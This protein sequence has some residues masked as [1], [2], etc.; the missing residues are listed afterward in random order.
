[1]IE[2]EID[3]KS[4]QVE[5][6]KMIIEVADEVG[7]NIPRF[8]YHKKLSVAAN[9]RMCLV[10]VEK[11][12]KPLPACATPVTPGMK[13][14]TQSPKAIDS[15]RGVMEFLLINHPLDCP[16]C[17]QGGE[18]ELQDLSMGYGNDS[19]RFD[20]GKRSVY[21]ENLGP[22]IA[23]YMT[24]CIQCTR[25]VR[26]GTEIAGIRE[27]GAT[28]RGENMEIETYVQ[29]AMSSELSGNIIDLCPV[30]ALTSKP[31]RFQARPWE[32]EQTASVAPHDCVGSNIYIHT[33]RGELM[34]VVPRNQDEIN[35]CWLSDRDRFSYTAVHSSK[36][37][38]KPMIKRD[39]KWHE[40]DWAA[41][42]YYAVEGFQRTFAATSADQMGG[43]ISPSATLEEHFLFQKC[44]R[45]LGTSNIDH[46]VRAVDTADQDD[47]PLFPTL[48]IPIVELAN[49]ANVLLIGSHIQHEQPLLSHR[50]R[51][52]VLQGANVACINPVDYDFNFKVKQKWIVAPDQIVSNLAALIKAWLELSPQAV[53]PEVEKFIQSIEVTAAH[54]ETV[55]L[56]Q[57]QSL[58]ILLGAYVES[59]PQA[60]TLRWLAHQ[61]AK[62]TLANMGC[63]TTG[64]NAAGAWLAGAVPNRSTAG[65]VEAQQGLNVDQQFAFNLPAYFL[66]NVEPELDCVNAQQALKALNNA[67]WVVTCSSFKSETML[68]YADVI[69]PLAT[70]AENEGTIINIEGRWQSLKPAIP[71]VG[72]SKQGWK[73]L[74]VLG[75][76]FDL[77]HFDYQTIQNVTEE[78]QALKTAAGIKTPSDSF[79]PNF[80]TSATSQWSRIVSWPIYRTDNLVRHSIP[81]QNTPTQSL[82]SIRLNAQSAKEL[83]LKEN[84]LLQVMQNDK[85]V[86]LPWEIDETI[87]YHCFWLPA[88]YE[89]TSHLDGTDTA[90]EIS[91]A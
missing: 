69:L 42:M 86:Q 37:L 27:L 82:L 74:R 71:L 31:F 59:H 68:E 66:F 78:I 17:D 79:V 34:R 6:G 12:P 39:G 3:G 5:Q 38:Q 87:P 47:M 83:G 29:H 24:R 85:A 51:Q 89:E 49:Q 64:A 41:A 52:A 18:C 14:F 35:E 73:I 48:N 80:E 53:S 28:G 4:L 16:I 11:S 63:L 26:F 36:R 58:V 67:Q 46:R 10:E 30:G 43:V 13:V 88:G 15:Q 23:T 44:L 25:C 81:L 1:M 62:F 8:C 70:F 76:L 77:P 60:A 19:S 54:R 84:M 21:D 61:L 50:V 2:I 91:H 56:W 65:V 55:K 20:E 57:N 32:L 22:L 45:K 9:C 7:I 75:N 90:L 33:R 40:V 72:E